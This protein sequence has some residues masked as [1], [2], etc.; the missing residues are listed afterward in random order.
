MAD[1]DADNLIWFEVS[2][3]GEESFYLDLTQGDSEVR[4][5]YLVH[6]LSEK[7]DPVISVYIINPQ[8]KVIFARR[9]KSLGEFG[10][11]STGTGQY[12]FIFS[13]VRH[14]NHKQVLFSLQNS[15]EQ[16][17]DNF[18]GEDWTEEE[19]SQVDLEEMEG[20]FSEIENLTKELHSGI[21][22]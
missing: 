9:N 1:F 11:N 19:L 15:E 17:Q 21:M 12:K 22:L 10:F 5:T 8:G 2:P 18:S 4:G 16:I 20:F 3:K 7:V 14:K 13:N 6:G